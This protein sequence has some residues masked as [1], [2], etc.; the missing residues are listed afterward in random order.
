MSL[1]NPS[2]WKRPIDMVSKRFQEDHGCLFLDWVSTHLH[3][4]VDHETLWMALLNEVRQSA[5]EGGIGSLFSG[6]HDVSY[7]TLLTALI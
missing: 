6:I 2:P 3:G 1:W 5:R 4:D 7:H